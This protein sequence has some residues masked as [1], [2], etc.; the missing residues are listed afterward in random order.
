MI[1]QERAHRDSQPISTIH[2]LRQ[3]VFEY[4]ATLRTARDYLN[5]V[6]LPLSPN[7]TQ[8]KKERI[9]KI[10]AVTLISQRLHCV[11]TGIQP[12]PAVDD[13]SLI[14]GAI[15]DPYDGLLD[16]SDFPSAMRFSQDLFGV[17]DTDYD[18]SNHAAAATSD[19]ERAFYGYLKVLQEKIPPESFPGFWRTLKALHFVQTLSLL[20]RKE[21]WQ[22]TALNT[23]PE[24][25]ARITRI[26][27]GLNTI[28][29]VS[30]INPSL[31]EAVENITM[32][33][34]YTVDDLVN[35]WNQYIGRHEKTLY[36]FGHNALADAIFEAGAYV[37]EIDD[38]E[39]EPDDRREGYITEFTERPHAARQFLLSA[40]SKIGN[41]R[42][43]FVQAGVTQNRAKE[44][45]AYLNLFVVRKAL[46][47]FK[48]MNL[49]NPVFFKS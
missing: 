38:F 28:L 26:K 17:F 11:V 20:Q 22:K 37:Q 10:I 12:E 23:T 7:F 8:E 48:K 16:Q 36:R 41:I 1:R 27:G 29:F 2:I 44:L 34:D 25:L 45:Q 47:R 40:R 4:K 9:A 42:N 18:I 39:D 21:A 5:S 31:A 3:G 33:Q 13:Q 30:F 15:I 6:L 35:L 49:Y 43:A 46:K 14:M 19:D 24:E 32:P